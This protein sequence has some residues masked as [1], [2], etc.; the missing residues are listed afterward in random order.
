MIFVIWTNNEKLK[1]KRINDLVK[2]LTFSNYCPALSH[3]NLK[4]SQYSI[5]IDSVP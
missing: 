5:V 3:F 2:S 1:Y 4:I